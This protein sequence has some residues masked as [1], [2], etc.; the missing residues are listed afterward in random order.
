MPALRGLAPQT[1]G[2]GC[3]RITRILQDCSSVVRSPLATSRDFGM[4]TSGRIGFPREFNKKDESPDVASEP[5]PGTGQICD[6]RRNR[7][8]KSALGLAVNRTIPAAMPA[9]RGCRDAD[10]RALTKFGNVH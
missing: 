8:S 6:H 10:A 9:W 7:C 5:S 2:F 1:Q 4:T 3:F